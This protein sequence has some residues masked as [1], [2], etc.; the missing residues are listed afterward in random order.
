MAS[1]TA[2]DARRGG[3]PGRDLHLHGAIRTEQVPPVS[4][5]VVLTALDLEYQ[6]VRRH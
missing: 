2:A 3:R 4:I 1:A 5:V 6:A